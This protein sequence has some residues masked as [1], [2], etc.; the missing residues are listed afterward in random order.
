[1]IKKI[2]KKSIVILAIM[3]IGGFGGIIAD[4]YVFPYLGSTDFF[5]KHDFL[6]RG[7]EDVTIINKTEQVFVKEETSIAKISNQAS[8]SVVS[9]VVYPDTDARSGKKSSENLN[10]QYGTG[11]IITSD[12]LIMTY[13]DMVDPSKAKFKVI[14]S[15]GSSYDAEV[16]GRDSYSNLV[17][18]KIGASNL[19]AVSFGNSDDIKS[20]EKVIAIGT[21]SS[22]FNHEYVAGLV[23]NFDATFNLAGKAV[24]SSEKLE[25]VFELDMQSGPDYVGGPVVD[26]MGQVIGVTGVNAAQNYFAIPSN[27]I[28]EIVSRAIKKEL[29]QDPILG[30]YYVPLTKSYALVNGLKI[31]QGALIFSGSGQQGLAIIAGSPAQKAGLQLND[32][33]TKVN[34]QAISAAAPLSELLYEHKKGDAIELTIIRGG[35]ELKIPAQL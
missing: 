26:Y 32:I 1:M 27:K 7:S 31:D 6:K 28:S 30:I 19:S 25:G 22:S 5:K 17:F 21:A 20:G 3:V 4:R 2:S 9:I 11:L 8:S 14:T 29:D 35:Q 18:L 33:I 10:V 12:G 34:E 16:S 24:S 15:D 13:L 23:S